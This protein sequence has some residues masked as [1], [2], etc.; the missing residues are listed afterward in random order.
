MR[1]QGQIRKHIAKEHQTPV[2][3]CQ[4]GL[5]R[6]VVEQTATAIRQVMI[7]QKNSCTVTAFWEIW[8]RM[9]AWCWLEC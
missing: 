2:H 9:V 3:V 7:Q 6:M 4:W 1:G 5:T 8:I